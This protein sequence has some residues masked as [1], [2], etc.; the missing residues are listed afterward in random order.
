MATDNYYEIL[1]VSKDASDKDIKK[2]YRKLAK[3]LHPDHNKSEDAG[4]KFNEVRNAYDILSD[5]K[6]RAAY[7]QYGQAG[8]DG[9]ASGAGG[10]AGGFSGFGGS[11][12]FG[13]TV[14]MGDL[15]DIFNTFFSGGFSNGFGEDMGGA[16][17][18]GRSRRRSA[19]SQGV[20]LRY[21]IKLDFLEAIK[22]GEY[23]ISV[24][25]EIL[26]EACKGTGAEGGKLTEC[27]T[28]GGQG[29]VR[30][31]QNSFFGQVSVV[32]E[33]PDCQGQG[34]KAAKKCS[35]CS[36]NGTTS[37]KSPVKLKVPAGSYD[38]M[39]LKFRHGG[40]F[41]KGG[42]E[43]GDLYIELSVEPD[44]RFERRDNDIYSTALLSAADVVLG[45]EFDVD[46]VQ[47]NITLK[48][49]AGTQPSTIFRIKG[50]GSPQVGN[51]S[52]YGDHYLKV[53]VV[54]PKKLSREE[55]KLWEELK[56]K[57]SK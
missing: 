17:S 9:F 6:K 39:V 31:M 38:G 29:R 47:G 28:C 33:C 57:D 51:E 30:R 21:N 41:A 10:G 54:I 5:S 26:C 45:T 12:G 23:E 20:D 40:S 14:D 7:D 8:V 36:G 53:E 13:Q 19:V 22:G 44:E 1:G 2:A 27:S 3:E 32:T 4:K 24:N 15:G 34:K 55:K 49:P 43:A 25:R 37:Q 42:S 35:K 56:T 46:T 52:I 11:E 16:F 48:I 50:K 18:G